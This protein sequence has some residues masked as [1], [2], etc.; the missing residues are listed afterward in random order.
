MVVEHM[1]RVID[2]GGEQAV[3]VGSDFDGAIVPPPDLWGGE[4]YPRLVQHMLDRGWSQS[5]IRGCLGENFL[6]SFAELRPGQ[7]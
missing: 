5:R 6:R 2:A 7:G 1:E 4:T 3:A